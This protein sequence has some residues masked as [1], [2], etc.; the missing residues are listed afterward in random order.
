MP[1]D[2]KP[3]VIGD[4]LHGAACSAVLP[5]SPLGEA[6]GYSL[7]NWP[8]LQED[9]RPGELAIDNNTAG[10]TLTPEECNVFSGI[11]R[12]LALLVVIGMT[13]DGHWPQLTDVAKL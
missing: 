9:A 7:N 4:W 10:R 12:R 1:R 5:T 13:L 6:V 3:P 8:A 2:D 11:A